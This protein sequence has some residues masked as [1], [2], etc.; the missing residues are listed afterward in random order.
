MGEHRRPHLTLFLC[1]SAALLAAALL[2]PR[3]PTA[4]ARERPAE[5]TARGLTSSASAVG[6]RSNYGLRPAARDF[7][8]A[9]LACQSA[10]PPEALRRLRRW[11]S[12]EFADQL[13]RLPPTGGPAARLRRLAIAPLGPDPSAAVLS[14]SARGPLGRQEFSFF[15][16]RRPGGWIALG[17]AQ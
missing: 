11:T 7:L 13:L 16:E 1:L 17:P 14:G 15:F 5:R 8:A 4:P 3:E 2:L 6:P 10:R 12:P 9:Y